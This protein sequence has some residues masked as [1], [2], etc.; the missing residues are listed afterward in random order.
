LDSFI[1]TTESSNIELGR[2]CFYYSS[3]FKCN[4]VIYSKTDP[5]LLNFIEIHWVT[6]SF[7][8]TKVLDLGLRPDIN[9]NC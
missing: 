9:L 6:L 8:E 4:F 2:I 5:K 1:R 3:V 7:T